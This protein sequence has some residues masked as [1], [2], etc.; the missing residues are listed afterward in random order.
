MRDLFLFIKRFAWKYKGA[1]FLSVIFNTLTAFFTIFSFAFLIPILQMLFGL[2]NAHYDFIPWGEGSLKDVA[3]NNFYYF[4]DRLI[5]SNGAN[6]ALLVLAAILI[7]MTILKTGTYYLSEYTIIPLRNGV[8]KDIRDEMYAKI[9]SLPIGFFSNERKGDIIARI[10]GDVSEVELSV[11]SSIMSLIRYPIMIV[12]C[13]AVMIYISWQLTLF[14]FIMIPLFGFIMGIIGQKLRATSLKMQQTWGDILSTTEETIGGLRVVKAFNAEEHMKRH[15]FS[16]TLSYYRISN[17]INR[18]ICLAHPVSET[19]G[20]V[21]VAILLCFG[22]SLIISGHSS[23]NAA[24]FIYYLVIFYSIINPAK[25]LSKTGY[26]IRKGMAALG[27]IDEILNAENHIRDPKNPVELPLAPSSDGGKIEFKNVS[28]S[29]NSERL[30]LRDINL[31]VEPGS[32]VAI[33]G[34]SG[35]GKSTLVDLVPRFWDPQQG[36]VLVNGVDVRRLRVHD[37]R[38]LMGNV[39]QEA[40]LFNDTFFNNIAF[41][42]PNATEEDVIRAAKIANAHDFIMQTEKGYQTLVG[43][44]GNR[45]SGGQRQRV[46]IARAILKNPPVLILDEATSALDTESERLVQDALE[47]LMKN[48]TTIV[49]AHRLSTIFKADKICVMHDGRIIEEGTHNEL[50]ALKGHYYR[51]VKLQSA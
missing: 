24:E 34:Q 1:F 38:S 46:S 28:F 29:Y 32:T 42:C 10:S 21:A 11:M 7:A 27:R 16:Q 4:I 40:I 44:R 31:S 39:N 2:N 48:R 47:H 23:I 35:S 37:L 12:A 49:I 15:F 5:D 6:T 8:L 25:D 20:T 3:V 9:V 22:G 51:L 17:R 33:V 30:V 36:E 41:G 14:V 50:L 13:L 26:T 45:L 19:I 43:D 18:R